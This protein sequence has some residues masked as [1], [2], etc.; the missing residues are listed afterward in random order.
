G[1]SHVVPGRLEQA[2]ERAHARPADTDEV[3]AQGDRMPD[4]VAW[5]R[6]DMRG[7]RMDHGPRSRCILLG[8]RR[9]SSVA[10]LAFQFT[11][12]TF[13]HLS[14][15]FCATSVIGGSPALTTMAIRPKNPE[16]SVQLR[17]A[18]NS[19]SVIPLPWKPS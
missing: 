4:L 16:F 15:N 2:R 12:S 1:A 17:I 18:R 9:G 7:L 11:I 10:S 8:R 14:W 19:Q 13:L 6:P 3:N 5:I